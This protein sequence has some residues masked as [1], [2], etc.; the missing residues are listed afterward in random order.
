MDLESYISEFLLHISRE[1]AL[2][3]LTVATYETSLRQFVDFLR[4]EFPKGLSDPN[5]IDIIVI[6][7]FVAGLVRAGYKVSS[8]HSKVAAVR[9]FFRFLYSRG[10]VDVNYARH[11][12]LQRLPR[13][14]P[15]FLDFAQINE[16]LMLP[17]TETIL[18][19]R[20]AAILELLYAT[21][22]R[23]SE[24]VALDLPDVDFGGMQVRVMGKGGKE[25]I[26]PFGEAAKEA[27]E[28]Y[29]SSA[30]PVLARGRDT[31]ALFLSKSGLRLSRADVYRIVRRYL[32]SVSE[33]CRG[34]HSLRHTF[35][36][37]LL[38]MGADL[39][40]VKELL[41]HASIGTTQVYTHTT[42]ER[43]KRVY[44]KAHPR[45]KGRG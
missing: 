11:V 14:P 21:G 25:R 3:R 28:L 26:V 5:A 16:A 41:G 9:A 17:N 1:R 23:C 31:P 12:R 33:S 43:L 44:R 38:E 2:S 22:I 4:E 32:S 15:S 6:R 20:D 35:A 8:I 40:S 34:P 39:M 19:K 10:V 30:R 27:L 45:E 13:K 37:H 29:I 18:G 7:G 36:T 24:L 42:V